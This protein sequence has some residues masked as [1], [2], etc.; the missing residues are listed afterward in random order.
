MKKAMLRSCGVVSPHVVVGTNGGFV[1]AIKP[2]PPI[3]GNGEVPS[4]LTFASPDLGSFIVGLDC[5]DLN[6]DGS[7][8]IVC[9]CWLD[10]GSYVDWKNGD[11]D[12]NRGN[13]YI[14]DTTRAP[15]VGPGL[16]IEPVT[17][18][19]SFPPPNGGAGIGAAV[20]GVNIDDVDN[21]GSKEIWCVDQFHVYL[22]YRSSAGGAS[23]G[24]WKVATRTA[25]LGCF[26]GSYNRL[27][28]YKN[29]AGKT[30]RLIVVSNGY[31]M[32][33]AVDPDAVP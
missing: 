7:D 12:M 1:Y 2:G 16:G 26:P 9:G 20:F 32:E 18:D 10:D 6:A 4:T 29:A 33:F 14:I 17:G 28:P 22:L 24:T 19:S 25:D 23:S 21:D 11:A 15:V 5:K 31:V 30:V 13:L 8:E 3:A 27:F